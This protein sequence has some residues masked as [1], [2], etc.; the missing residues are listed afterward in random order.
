QPGKEP[1]HDP[2]TS[3]YDRRPAHP[4][5]LPVHDQQLH[6]PGGAVRRTL[7]ALPGAARSRAHSRL[8]VAS[9]RERHLVGDL[10]PER[11]GASLFVPGDAEA[12]L[13][14]GPIALREET[15][16]VAVRVE[17]AG[18]VAVLRRYSPPQA[19]NGA[20]NYLRCWPARLGGSRSA[21]AGHR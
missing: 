5:L 2:V 13:A 20:D 17:S 19:P 3:T 4:Q 16:A 11:G 7:W 14:S 6:P 8:P 1:S 12:T 10:Q 9:A 15:E 18:G 21:R